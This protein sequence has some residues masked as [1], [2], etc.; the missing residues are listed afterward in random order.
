MQKFSFRLASVL[1]LRE[2]Q[3]AVERE[4]LQRLL[5]EAARLEQS[6]ASLAEERKE[7]LVFVQNDPD[8]SGF[9][10]M[11]ALSAFLLGSEARAI[12]LRE[13]LRHTQ[14]LAAEQRQRVIAADRNER[15]LLKLKEKK[16]AEWRR[17]HDLELEAVAQECWAAAQR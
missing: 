2:V 6:L 11:R 5:S 16:F 1:R 8:A 12:T 13:T 10:G 9:N 4:K 3:L 14:N 7:A 17:Q 15:L